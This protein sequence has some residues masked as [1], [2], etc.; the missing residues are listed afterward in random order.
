MFGLKP[1]TSTHPHLRSSQMTPQMT[2]LVVQER[3]TFPGMI[4][5]PRGSVAIIFTSLLRILTQIKHSTYWHKAETGETVTPIMITIRQVEMAVT[6][7]I[8]PLSTTTP[9]ASGGWF[10]TN[11]TTGPMVRKG[12]LI[13]QYGSLSSR[14]PLLNHSH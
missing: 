10:A 13:S 3:T 9:S 11:T 12:P 5:V 2:Y 14:R 1:F 4:I 6:A 7:G 8:S